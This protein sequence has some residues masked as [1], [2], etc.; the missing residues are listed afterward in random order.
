MSPIQ[1]SI[2]LTPFLRLT[3]LILLFFSFHFFHCKIMSH[4]LLTPSIRSARG[5]RECEE[6]SSTSKRLKRAISDVHRPW[7][8]ELPALT[9][10]ENSF[11]WS[12]RC[13]ESVPE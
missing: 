6:Y 9:S 11:S 3:A 7:E 5:K 4:S 13:G 12:I 1:L 10:S 2:F 8:M